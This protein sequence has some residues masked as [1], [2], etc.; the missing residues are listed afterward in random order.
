MYE[1]S[2]KLGGEVISTLGFQMRNKE[3]VKNTSIK[4]QDTLAVLE[5]DRVLNDVYLAK[6]LPDFRLGAKSLIPCRV[7][8][9]QVK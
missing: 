3:W 1:E 7:V 5:D 6:Y 8:S 4:N 2:K 9:V